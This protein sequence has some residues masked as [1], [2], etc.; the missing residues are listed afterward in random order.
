MRLLRPIT[1]CVGVALTVLLSAA[2]ALAADPTEPASPTASS[3]TT[4]PNAATPAAPP[5]ATKTEP[6]TDWIDPATGHRIIR[7]SQEPGTSSMYFH[8]NGYTDSGKLFVT[9]A[10]PPDQ[11]TDRRVNSPN[12]PLDGGSE[13][14]DRGSRVPGADGSQP[15]GRIPRPVTL[16]TI[17]L[18]T[19]GV[20]PPKMDKIATC[21]A[22][23]MVVGKKSGNLYYIRSEMVDGNRVD[24]VVATN[25]DTHETREIGTLPFRGGSGLAVNADETLL[26]GS[27]VVAGAPA[28]APEPIDKPAQKLMAAHRMTA[29]R[30]RPILKAVPRRRAMP[31]PTSR[32][33]PAAKAQRNLPS[34]KFAAS[35]V[36]NEALPPAKQLICP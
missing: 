21:I 2:I 25:L 8:Q 28:P 20:S 18:T 3:P 11:T 15:R 12:D 31:V 32:F 19:L 26:G 34:G 14:R 22:R 13:Q 23:G 33:P 35:A 7:L 10:A 30:K 4:S 29:N 36:A 27:Y 6:P 17:D 5:S 9:I 1:A 16:A 24:K